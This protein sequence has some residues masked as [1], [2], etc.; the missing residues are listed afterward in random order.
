MIFSVQRFPLG[1]Y[2]GT[3]PASREGKFPLQKSGSA[4][5]QAV[6]RGGGVSDP[7]DVQGVCGCSTEGRGQWAW[8]G[9][10]DGRTRQ[11]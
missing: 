9:G 5:M 1:T 11:S 3:S 8:W 4:L 10:A 7:G 6:L 2:R